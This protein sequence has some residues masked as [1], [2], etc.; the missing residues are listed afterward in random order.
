MSRFAVGASKKPAATL[1]DP[2]CTISL[3]RR[4]GAGGDCR[5]TAG[6][7]PVGPGAAEGVT[8]PPR[9]ALELTRPPASLVMV[10]WLLSCVL[11]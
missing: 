11:A 1:V 8:M 7:C 10:C 6:R 3:V 4:P 9:H 5:R 2:A